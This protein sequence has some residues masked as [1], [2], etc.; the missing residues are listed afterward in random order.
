MVQYNAV[1]NHI[2][3]TALNNL[4]KNDGHLRLHLNPNLQNRMLTKVQPNRLAI[5]LRI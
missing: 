2:N 5:H 3:D 1:N 4:A